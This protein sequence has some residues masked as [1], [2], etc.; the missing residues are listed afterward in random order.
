MKNAMDKIS[1]VEAEEATLGSV[2]INPEALD[3]IPWLKAEDF[4]EL[5]HQWIFQTM[6]DLAAHNM[7]ID[8]L[9]VVEALRQSGKL[10][11]VGGAAYI[12]YL[13]N[14][15]PTHIY[16]STYAGIVEIAARKRR[17]MMLAGEIAQTAAEQP[18]AMLLPTAMKLVD[19]LQQAEKAVSF[20][21]LR[22]NLVHVSE[23]KDLPLLTWLLPG[24]IPEYGLVLVYGPS[25]VGKSFFTL[26][27]ALRLAEDI[28]VVYIASEGEAGYTIRVAAWAR[29]HQRDID[30]YNLYFYMNIVALLD[31]RERAAFVKLIS[32]IHPKL[33]IVD[34]LAHAMLPG[35]E[36]DTRDMGLFLKASKKIQREL[37]CAIV[38]VHHTSKHSEDE[39]GSSVLRGS[40]D[41][42]I[43]LTEEDQVIAV[44]C[45]KSKDTQ[46]FA[47]RYMRL[48][49]VQLP[50]G[51]SSPVLIP[52]SKIV[53]LKSDPLT[54]LQLRVLEAFGL[55]CFQ[56]GASLG[57]IAE[58]TTLNRGTV[59]RISSRLAVLGFLIR[60]GGNYQISND[61]KA[62]LQSS[63]AHPTDSSTNAKESTDDRA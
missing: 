6:K 19:M 34:T 3:Q 2:L 10:E 8:N 39:R 16:V 54:P 26:D 44:T 60:V 37:G 21:P 25:G 47:T 32:P 15:T 42:M 55:D 45:T 58:S 11:S 29:H 49:P 63:S 53:Q 31:D 7:A 35:N 23:L 13:I 4:F 36:N 56:S 30:R 24:E 59:Q 38:M 28:S 62:R 18:A 17:A 33:I 52:A 27:Y 9:T 22:D 12:T 14:C 43:R 57:D 40:C 46:P 61:G 51:Q 1:S 20:D 48:L 5:K 50:D 41:M